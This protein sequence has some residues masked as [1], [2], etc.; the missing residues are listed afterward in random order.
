MTWFCW[1]GENG[2][3]NWLEML[4]RSAGLGRVG[5]QVV[6]V[7]FGFHRW[8]HHFGQIRQDLARSWRELTGSQ[9]DLVKSRLDL[10]EISLY[11]VQSDGF[12][13]NFRRR[14]PIFVCFHQRT[15]NIAGNFWLYARVRLLGFWERKPANRPTDVEFCGRRPTTDYRSGR[16]RRFS[17]RVRVGFSGKL[18][19]G[20]GWTVLA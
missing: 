14:T 9:R 6:L 1:V 18:S 13:V 11:L 12:Q 10:D 7:G 19:F 4:V 16:F 5:L 3:R 20:L 15:P 2:T 8:C 17:I